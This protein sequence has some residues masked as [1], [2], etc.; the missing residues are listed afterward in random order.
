MTLGG[1]I[2]IKILYNQVPVEFLRVPP[3]ACHYGK[4]LFALL[5][6]LYWSAAFC[7][8]AAVPNF[9]ALTSVITA[10]CFVQTSYVLPLVI[11]LAFTIRKASASTNGSCNRLGQERVM[12]LENLEQFAN[13]FWGKHRYSNTLHVVLVLAALSVG[14][15]GA[16]SA[17]EAIMEILKLPQVDT[18]TCQS[19]LDL[20]P[21]S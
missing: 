19:P 16:W 2:S 4:R 17:I 12:N 18:F 20:K 9:F 6:P 21:S 15:L 11:H 1:S 3:L 5:V 10:L 7:V 14:G 8:A 13:G